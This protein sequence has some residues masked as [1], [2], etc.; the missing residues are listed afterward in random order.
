MEIFA[1]AL[2]I[3]EVGVSSA[4]RSL[5][6]V[7]QKGQKTERTFKRMSGVAKGFWAALTVGVAAKVFG[8]ITDSAIE[9]EQATTSLRASVEST[10]NSFVDWGPHLDAVATKLA[11]ITRFSDDELKLAL[12]S[13]ITLTG[14]TAAS[15]RNL[16]LAADIAAK[17]QVPLA[18]AALIVS[19]AM[20]GQNASLSRLG[21]RIKEGEDGVAALA[22]RFSGFAEKDAQTFSG[23][24]ARMRN[25]FGEV[26]ESI[27]LIITGNKNM[28]GAFNGVIR[29]LRNTQLWIEEH[30]AQLTRLLD[31]LQT[32]G[33]YVGGGLVIAF[34]ALWTGIK[35]VAT[36]VGSLIAGF[37]EIPQILKMA[38]GSALLQIGT[39]VKGGAKLLDAIFGTDF[40]ASVQRSMIETGNAMM[41]NASQQIAL[42]DSQT[43]ATIN[44]IW[45]TSKEA[46]RAVADVSGAAPKDVR[47]GGFA[48]ESPLA[49]VFAPETLKKSILSGLDPGMWATLQNSI[50]KFKLKF[51][52][53]LT[54]AERVAMEAHERNLEIW[55][56]FGQQ[57]SDVF[58]DSL[59]A[60]IES[61][62]FQDFGKTL[63]AGLGSLMITM[64]KH[65][66]GFGALMQKLFAAISANP[67]L[68]GPVGIAVGVALIAL[69]AALRGAAK[70][71]GGGR[72][73]GGIG[74]GIG[75]GGAGG[76][77][78]D[79]SRFTLGPNAIGQGSRV[80]PR[81]E[82]H[83]TLIGADSPKLQRELVETLDNAE[84]RNIKPRSARG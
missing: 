61:G 50:P 22:A 29:V 49:N 79:V 83:F 52:M 71:G 67:L 63:L 72:G 18:D 55:R 3:Q 21:I 34:K 54:D 28:G 20:N 70:G 13:M 77:S 41:A 40:A 84:A 44:R 30:R 37:Q 23:S 39:F 60:G 42:I 59:V 26:L 9:A 62:S 25:Q 57:L 5:E 27:G 75:G 12:G 10:G 58:T 80:E 19:K 32:V 64:G 4:L 48:E 81:K 14:K 24:L 47:P 31:I 69:G 51:E 73:V 56:G 65:I 68:A 1:L 15:T 2:K 11:T 43:R 46:K 45:S 78:E 6:A 76:R 7:D 17:R 38:L 33:K 82:Y 16:A 8:A 53:D 66:I 74:G 36:V 35:V